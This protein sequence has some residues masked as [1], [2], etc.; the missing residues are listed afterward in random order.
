M[1]YQRWKAHG[2]PEHGG[3][4][5]T[6]SPP[7]DTADGRLCRRCNAVK[8]PA[9]FHRDKRATGGY[10]AVCKPCRSEDMKQWY[11][12][13]QPRQMQRA[14]DRFARD[15]EKIRANDVLRYERHREKRIELAAAVA[16]RRRATLAAA[17]GDSDITVTRL[18]E[19]DGDLCF[20]CSVTMV[21]RAARRGTYEPRRAS[22]E[23]IVP[24]ARGG[25]HVW[26]NVALACLS[27]NVR[28]NQRTV[29]EWEASRAHETVRSRDTEG[30]HA[31]TP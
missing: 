19:R 27:C 25:G 24:L 7:V 28:K 10:R 23:H 18:R 13:N 26:D 12:E 21:F 30:V 4:E 22:I 2:D 17:P 20:Y 8:P 11:A 14:R 16:H 15:I 5:R 31:T 9:E 3:A 6:W 29:E 1:H